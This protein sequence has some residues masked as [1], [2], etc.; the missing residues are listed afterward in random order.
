MI[1]QKL[2]KIIEKAKEKQVIKLNLSGIEIEELPPEIGQLTTLTELKLQKN[3]LRTLPPE[4]GMLTNLTSLYLWDNQISELPPEIGKLTKLTEL[5]LSYNELRELPLEMRLLTKLTDLDLRYNPLESPPPEIVSKGAKALV[6]YLRQQYK[7]GIDYVYEAKLLIVGESGAGK[8]T[9]AKK[10]KKP[11]YK[12]RQEDSTHGIDVI[13]WKFSMLNGQTFNVNIW[14]FGGQEIYHATHQFFLTKRSLYILVADIRKEDTDFY[15]WLNV[16]ELLSD[17]SPLLIVKNE[18]QDRHREINER[19][20]RGQFTNLKET[21]A[22][23]LGTNRGLSK[24]TNELKH[25]ISTLPHVGQALPKTWKAVRKQLERDPRNFIY[26]SEFLKIC[27]ENGFVRHKDKEQLSDYLHDLGVCLHYQDDPVLNNIVILKTEWAT[28]AVYKVLDNDTVMK[29]LGRFGKEDL[30]K[31]W[32]KPEYNEMHHALVQ[33]MMKFRLCY[34]L[35]NDGDYIAPQ[36]LMYNSPEYKWDEQNN[37]ILKYEYEFMPKGIIS[38]F[39]VI[40]HDRIVDQELVWRSG[41][42]LKR[43]DT[44]AEITEDYYRRAM[45]IRLQGKHK[46]EFLAII[47]FELDKIHDSYK[48][49]RYKKFIP[50]NCLECENQQNPHFYAYHI[51]KSFLEKNQEVIQCLVSTEMVNVKTLIDDVFVRT[52]SVQLGHWVAEI[53]GNIDEQSNPMVVSENSAEKKGTTIIIQNSSK[54]IAEAKVDTSI[55]AEMINVIRFIYGSLNNLQYEVAQAKPDQEQEF[56]NIK[57]SVEKMA[58][59]KTKEE[60]IKSETLGK[61]KRFLDNINDKRTKLGKA[62]KGIR[63]GYKIVQEIADYYNKIADWIGFP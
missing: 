17:N 25:Y 40:M 45:K 6:G 38:Q 49:L 18:M 55:S 22:T 8:T 15:Y 32:N 39:I 29:N 3:K 31:I 33:L 50:C 47:T 58:Q 41:V 51:L 13:R 42:I 20:L 26:L 27:Q 48:R 23:N 34:Y 43:E 63:S 24:V 53:G 5:R 57:K 4:I 30:R 37:L 59:L 56:E 9:L 7:D 19:E 10:I 28:D 12:L 14:D 52:Q 44:L 2:V 60:I 54:A 1:N 46:K 36:L 35:P 11:R 16:V 62:I 21:L 61:L